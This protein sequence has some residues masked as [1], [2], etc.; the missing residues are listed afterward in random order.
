MD[1]YVVWKLLF[2][3]F[4]CHLQGEKQVEMQLFRLYHN[5][6]EIAEF[7]KELRRKQG[8]LEKVEKKKEK[9]EEVQKEKKKEHTRVS[10]EMSKI[11]QD[12]RELVG[13]L[14]QTFHLHSSNN[15]IFKLSPSRIF[16]AVAIIV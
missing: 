6:K 15:V 9:A 10:R 13:Y 2:I 11:D 14:L 4:S 8:D 7:E 3:L 16:I 5:E 12:I 1:L